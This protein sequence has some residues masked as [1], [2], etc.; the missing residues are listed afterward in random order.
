M[1][2]KSYGAEEA[3]A[4]L[5]KLLE[6]AHHGETTFITRRG[7]P[8]AVVAPVDHVPSQRAAGGLMPLRGTGAGLWGADAARTI[9]RMRDEWS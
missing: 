2:K 6:R 5:P 4:Q 1:G 9:R 3:R 8:Y 7:R